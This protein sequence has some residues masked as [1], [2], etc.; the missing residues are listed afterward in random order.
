MSGQLI[1]KDEDQRPYIDDKRVLSV[2]DV[3]KINGLYDGFPVSDYFL[4]VGQARHKVVELWVKGTLDMKTVHAD[5]LPSLEAYLEFENKTGFKA[6]PDGIEKKVWN[7]AL[8]LATRLDLL[9]KFPDGAEVIV[10]LKS[11][12]V[13]KPTAWQTAGQDIAL[14][15]PRRK[16]YGLS[17]PKT[18]RPNVKA[19]TS[20]DDYV[21]FM[22]FVNVARCKMEV[23]N[24]SL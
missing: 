16:R 3:L 23:L 18:G 6:L 4:W 5:I 21:M 24:L 14:G 7:P 2:T 20:S 17:V 9:G 10:E 11:G 1:Y 15:G 22:S 19:F 8:Q 12:S 13:A